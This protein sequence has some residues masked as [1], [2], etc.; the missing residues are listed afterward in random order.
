MEYRYLG[1]TG[2]KVSIISF[3][4]MVNHWG[5]KPQETN[6]A[7]VAKCLEYGINFFDSAESYGGGKA[8]VILGQSFQ[9][10]KL[11]RK[12]LVISTKLFFGA[13]GTF[14][15]P[16]PN[17]RGL[18]RKKVIEGAKASLKRMQLDYVDIIFAHRYDFHTPLEE[19]CRAFSW[20]IENEYALYWGTSDWSADQISQAITLCE[21]LGL[22]PPACEQ[23]NYNM[24]V[25]DKFEKEYGQVFAR[26]QYGSTV[27]SPLAM[28]ILSGRY[29]DGTAPEAGRFTNDPTYKDTVLNQFFSPEKKDKSIKILQD[30]KA[31]AEEMGYTQPALAIAWALVNKD[32]STLILGFSKLQYVDENLKALEIYKKWN[33]ELEAKIEAI[34]KNAPQLDMDFRNFAPLTSRRQVSLNQKITE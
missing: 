2:L 32:V 27:W 3:G 6:D 29:N 12:D 16:H 33:K 20:L 18:S 28:G 7:I 24:L 22:H 25:R 30:I 10:L 19:V 9:N 5:D 13:G 4:N 11:N 26:F 23:P 1:K 14:A 17:N 15:K 21:S 8:E 31:L 34:L